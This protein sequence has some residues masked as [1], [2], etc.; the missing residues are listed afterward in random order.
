MLRYFIQKPIT[1]SKF[2]DV[3][4]IRS[5]DVEFDDSPNNFYPCFRLRLGKTRMIARTNGR[6]H[7][8]GLIPI[9]ADTDGHRRIA[10][11]NIQLLPRRQ[12]LSWDAGK[13]PF[14]KGFGPAHA[15]C[16]EPW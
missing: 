6:G 8:V 3:L 7:V 9:G 14:S 2:A 15:G 16:G 10:D 1:I 4:A 12:F 13:A 11:L 5:F